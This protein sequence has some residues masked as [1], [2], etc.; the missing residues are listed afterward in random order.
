MT[1]KAEQIVRDALELPPNVRAYVAEKLIESLDMTSAAE[2]SSEWKEEIRKRC[3]EMN[4]ETVELVDAEAV[5]TKGFS[6]L[7]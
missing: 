5:F 6:S 1:K 4:E 3:K 2:L 7:T